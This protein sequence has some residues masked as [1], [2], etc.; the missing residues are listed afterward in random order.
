[1]PKK[2]SINLT[3]IL[4]FNGINYN[5][6]AME[7]KNY[8][9]ITLLAQHPE[10]KEKL[11]PTLQQCITMFQNQWNWVDKKFIVLGA[12]KSRDTMIAKRKEAFD[13]LMPSS[14]EIA[15]FISEY[16]SGTATKQEAAAEQ[17]TPEAKVDIA[18]IK[19]TIQETRENIEELFE[20]L[21]EWIEESKTVE[22]EIPTV[23]VFS[24][25]DTQQ[26]IDRKP[27]PNFGKKFTVNPDGSRNYK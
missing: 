26:V 22:T 4:T 13:G 16:V 18:E 15:K 20:D 27:N 10:L 19:E 17:A 14:Q 24:Y 6:S 1:M 5:K 21:E 23:G 8:P 7:I 25:T 3:W 12:G 11:S 2:M 9:H